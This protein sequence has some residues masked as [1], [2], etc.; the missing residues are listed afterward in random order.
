MDVDEVLL[1]SYFKSIS[2]LPH[3][4]QPVDLTMHINCII[5]NIIVLFL[6][7]MT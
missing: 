1:N 2:T 3:L 4:T 5:Y 7:N 6:F